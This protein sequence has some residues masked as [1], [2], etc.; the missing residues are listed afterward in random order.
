MKVDYIEVSGFRGFRT[1][2]RITVPSGFLIVVGANGAGKSTLC[3]AVEFALTG[4]IRAASEH[5]E[6]GES[7]RDYLWWRGSEV[8]EMGY[9]EVG[10]VSKAGERTVVRRDRKGLT[11]TPHGDLDA[12]LISTGSS[13]DEPLGQ[14]CRTTILRDEEITGISVDLKE[15]D[16]FAFVRSALGATDVSGVSQRLKQIEEALRTRLT[17]TTKEYEVERE[18]VSSLGARL[19]QAR[20]DAA[21][22]AGVEDATAALT[23]IVGQPA[24]DLASLVS[25]AER[26]IAGDRRRAQQLVDLLAQLREM[27]RRKAEIETSEY[28]N[29]LATLDEELRRHRDTA[30]EKKLAA[31]TVNTSLAAAQR[32]TPFLA[33][34][35]QLVEHGQAVGLRESQCPLCGSQQTHEAFRDHIDEVRHFIARQ[36]GSIADLSKRAIDASRE[37]AVAATEAERAGREL[38]RA[39]AAA[40]AVNADISKALARAADVGVPADGDLT[41]TITAIARTIEELRRRGDTIEEALIVV[42]ASQAAG[43]VIELEREYSAAQARLVH[44]EGVRSKIARAQA[45]VHD[46]EHGTKRLQGELVDEQLAA[47]SPLLV[48]LYQRLRPHIDWP[49]VKYTVRGDV[50]RMLS[51]EVGAG[52]NPSFMF[53]SGQRRAAGLAFLLAIHLSRS[54]CKLD[55]LVLDDP[56]QH[57]DDYRALHLTE[58]LAA[59]RRTGKQII[60]TVE[61][62]ALAD[63]LARR[64]RSEV[65]QHGG[66]VRL[67]YEA[68]RGSYVEDTHEVLPFTRSVLVPLAVAG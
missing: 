60:C 36:H 10:F 19:S 54:W 47:L 68:G 50:R 56:V 42:R 39:S 57:V 46:A 51:V 45:E 41:E 40:G 35:A 58:V 3:D 29:R 21:R 12:L 43:Q 16:R 25:M 59:I 61:D 63:L 62:S 9:V 7:V 5:K 30:A 37:A 34:L 26:I 48:E 6:K 32:E 53:S 27:A 14:L 66:T 44:A 65:G 64:L 8:S 17:A 18:R 2:T 11:L 4:V 38:E 31:D 67:G 1:T 24:E 23:S 33:S 13:L 20:A 52:L 28:Q 15:T 22:A 55:T 49:D